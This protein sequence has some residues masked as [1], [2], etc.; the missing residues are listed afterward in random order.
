MTVLQECEL[1]PADFLQQYHRRI[2]AETPKLSYLSA[3]NDANSPIEH[4]VSYFDELHI[5]ARSPA[6]QEQ[7]N[8]FFSEA[9][10]AAMT[11]E[12]ARV[13]AVRKMQARMGLSGQRAAAV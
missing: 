13:Y 7:Y 12:D 2:I 6:H 10:E 8:K 4:E 1:D 5:R 11:T 3:M 9:R